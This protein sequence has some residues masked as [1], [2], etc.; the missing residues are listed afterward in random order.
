MGNP[1]GGIILLLSFGAKVK[2]TKQKKKTSDSRFGVWT[3][4]VLPTLSNFK[5]VH[6]LLIFLIWWLQMAFIPI[7][8]MFI[9]QFALH[10]MADRPV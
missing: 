3:Q 4:H 5:T 10:H 9:N 2:K 1:S 8:Y 7:S 6:L